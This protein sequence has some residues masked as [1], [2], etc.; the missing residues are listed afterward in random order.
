MVTGLANSR[1]S[2]LVHLQRPNEK[3]A[4]SQEA[5]KDSGMKALALLEDRRGK[6]LKTQRA[7]H[8]AT[9]HDS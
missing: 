2:K 8:E 3:Q 4:S 9:E 7:L 5:S 6:H 1:N